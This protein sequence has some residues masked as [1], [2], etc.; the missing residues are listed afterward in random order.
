M[1]LFLL[2]QLAGEFQRGSNV[3]AADPILALH[4]IESH[5]ASKAA[6]HD[7]DRQPCPTN[8]G[9]AMTNLGIDHNSFAHEAK[10][11]IRRWHCQLIP[12]LIVPA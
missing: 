6:H 2:D 1:M 3:V 4:F 5:A 7:G 12:D 8:H 11:T 9:L 10:A